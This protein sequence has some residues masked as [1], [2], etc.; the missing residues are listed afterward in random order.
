MDIPIGGFDL[1]AEIIAG[2][3]EGTITATVDQQ[4]TRKDSMP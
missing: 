4:P 1:T 2:I 3:E